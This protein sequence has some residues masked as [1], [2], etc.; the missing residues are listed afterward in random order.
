MDLEEMLAKAVSE[1]LA[2][3]QAALPETVSKADVDAKFSDFKAE[4]AT[5]MTETVAKAMGEMSREGVGRQGT[6]LSDEEQAEKDPIAFLSK[7]A[8][9]KPFDELEPAERRAV[10]HL[11]IQALLAGMKE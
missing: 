8:A 5:L 4:I 10:A 2:K 9:A 7:K 1:L 6:V 3:Q 11:T